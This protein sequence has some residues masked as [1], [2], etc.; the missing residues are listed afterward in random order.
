MTGPWA[1]RPTHAAPPIKRANPHAIPVR[2]NNGTLIAHADQELEEKLLAA[3]AAEAFRRGPRR[4]L[5]LRPNISV[6]RTTR[7]WSVIEHLRKWL[8]DRRAAAYVTFKDKASDRL[9][10]EPPSEPIGRC[11]ARQ[12]ATLKEH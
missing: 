8:G 10:F 9:R 7:G 3:G 1:V 12:S 5:R 11:Q 6:P 2:L 4:Y